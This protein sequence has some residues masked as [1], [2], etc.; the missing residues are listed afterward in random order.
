AELIDDGA[1]TSEGEYVTV[2][3]S[4]EEITNFYTTSKGDR[5][6]VYFIVGTQEIEL[7][8]DIACPEEWVAGGWVSGTLTKCKWMMYSTTWELCPTDWTELTYAAPCATPEITL[9][10]AEASI[11]CGTEGATIYYTVDGNDPTETSDVYSSPVTLT[12][13]QTIK[14]KAFLDGHKPSDIASKKYTAGSTGESLSFKLDE[15]TTG[16]SSSSYVTS[17]VAFTKDEVSY[18]VNQWNP[19]TLQIKCN[20]SNAASNFSLYN[21]SAIPGK[22]T[23]ISIEITSGTIADVSKIYLQTSASVLSSAATSGANPINNDGTLE[24]SIEGSV[25]YFSFGTVKGGMSG[26]V[27]AGTI[28]IEYE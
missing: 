7:F 28:T 3:L 23:K 21:T 6:G 14:A 8:S 19:S 9:D 27:K 24:W 22:I 26:T 17:A 10:G 1:P 15:T 2:T 11:T 18:K 5:R 25:S 12:D 20:Q 16:S 4:N 13:G